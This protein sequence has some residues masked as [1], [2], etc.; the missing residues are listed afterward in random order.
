MSHN[1]AYY[2]KKITKKDAAGLTKIGDMFKA[3]P[4]STP[5]KDDIDPVPG[6]CNYVNVVPSISSNIA[7]DS[8]MNS[9]PISECPRP[10]AMEEE[11]DT[12][13]EIKC[14]VP[15]KRKFAPIK[16]ELEYDYYY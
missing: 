6:P 1:G 9:K 16:Y 4:K 10:E 11:T 8:V 3:M 12:D 7:M 2:V 5:A 15:D 14:M 13:E